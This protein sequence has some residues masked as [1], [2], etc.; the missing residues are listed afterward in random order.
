MF[1]SPP[2]LRPV[3]DGRRYGAVLA[4]PPWRFISYT[5]FDAD[6]PRGRRDV[7]R[8]Y[9]TLDLA[10]ICELP[11]WR[12][13]SRD[14]H[15]FLWATGPC[16]EHAFAVIR[17]WGFRYS[18]L[19]FN[20]VKLVRGREAAPAT[21]ADGDLHLGAGHTTRH[22]SELCLLAR[23]GNP[24]RRARDVR[25]VILA[26]VA[27]HSTKPEDCRERIERY[28]D[29]PY[30]ELFARTRRAGWDVWGDAFGGF[31]GAEEA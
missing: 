18:A 1:D 15:L 3:P 10:A 9:P 27:E 21:I 24:R 28:G 6:R 23:R 5:A 20:W 16:L 14:A 13:A 30:L 17:A 7:E 8:H 2:A 12:W 22:N 26:P 4:D 25:E 29:G 19:G 31:V 11:V